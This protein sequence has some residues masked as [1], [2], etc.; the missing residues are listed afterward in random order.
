MSFLL[1]QKELEGSSKYSLYNAH[2]PY[3]SPTDNGVSTQN[4][5]NAMRIENE[6]A[7]DFRG[8][9]NKNQK[10]FGS[11]V[12]ILIKQ[13]D[14]TH[15]GILVAPDSSFTTFYSYKNIA[16]NFSSEM[17]ET[18]FLFYE[19]LIV[20]GIKSEKQCICA[21]FLKGNSLLHLIVKPFQIRY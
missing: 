13:I 17:K 7:I 20:R 14:C 21:N 2:I 15:S 3:C 12:G 11:S 18:R 8:K 9:E 16:N 5:I 1:I 19:K 10:A 6:W 4:P